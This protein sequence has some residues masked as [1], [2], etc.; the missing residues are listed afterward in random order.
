[1][2]DDSG[3]VADTTD[4]IDGLDAELPDVELPDLEQPEANQEPAD[5]ELAA[6]ADDL[7]A[8]ADEAEAF[9]DGQTAESLRAQARDLRDQAN[10]QPTAR[11][12]DTRTPGQRLIDRVNRPEGGSGGGAGT[13][14]KKP[15]GAEPLGGAR[16]SLFGSLF[17]FNTTVHMPLSKVGGGS[18]TTTIGGVVTSSPRGSGS[19][20]AGRSS[21][22]GR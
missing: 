4:S 12:P 7:E 14:K 3:A 1:M 16:R 8:Q 17:T 15:K 22:R 19:R 5:A 10:L 18:R 21:R 13:G 6:E 9:G 2:S 11:V 20:I